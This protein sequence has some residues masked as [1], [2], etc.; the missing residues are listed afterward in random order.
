[1]TVCPHC[2]TDSATLQA[3]ADMIEKL[4]QQGR[5]LLE[6]L[7]GAE[8]T[9]RF[10]GMTPTEARILTALL[11]HERLSKEALMAVIQSKAVSDDIVGVYICRLRKK[12]AP[13]GLEI[14]TVWGDGY[15][16]PREQRED[17]KAKLAA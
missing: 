10:A 12:I 2:F 7:A 13:L 9:P 17:A 14:H 4:E 16:I 11:R 8:A 15:F 1:M 6:L 5:D 3:Q